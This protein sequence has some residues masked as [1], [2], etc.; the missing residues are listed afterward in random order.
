[1]IKIVNLPKEDTPKDYFRPPF[2]IIDGD[3]F[4]IKPVEQEPYGYAAPI[5]IFDKEGRV[6]E[7][8]DKPTVTPL[9]LAT[10]VHYYAR[11][12]FFKD[13]NGNSFE[14]EPF[15][16][17]CV[18]PRVIM[19]RIL[20]WWAFPDDDEFDEIEKGLTPLPTIEQAEK[21]LEINRF[22]GANRIG[23]DGCPGYWMDQSAV[24]RNVPDKIQAIHERHER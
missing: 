21:W 17:T 15:S 10:D 12:S 8:H 11:Q 6:F 24:L 18:D 13:R 4:L 14:C 1:M 5:G 19:A 20:T 23:E 2:F 3:D 9:Y 22:K 7:I 16:I